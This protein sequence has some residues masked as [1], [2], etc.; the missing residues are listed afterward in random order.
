MRRRKRNN[1]PVIVLLILVLLAA[2]LL[3]AMI[4]FLNTH[5]FVGGK[6][7]AN[8][9]QYL[10][11]RN[12]IMTTA[13]YDAIREKLPDCDIRWN[14]PFQNSVYPDDTASLSVRSLSDED[15]RVLS[16]FENLKEVDAV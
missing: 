15:L 9:A 13:R 1:K 16:Y 3:G 2:A 6:A 7:Y 11:L 14:I 10:D 12:Q 8:N 5:F 4:W